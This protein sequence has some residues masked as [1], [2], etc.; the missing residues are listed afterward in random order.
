MCLTVI[1]ITGNCY[2]NSSVIANFEHPVLCIVIVLYFS[3]IAKFEHPVLCQ[4][5]PLSVMRS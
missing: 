5:C 2:R 4:V 3:V 1:P